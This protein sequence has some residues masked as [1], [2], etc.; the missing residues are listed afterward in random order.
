MTGRAIAEDTTVF[1]IFGVAVV[2]CDCNGV[3]DALVGDVLGATV[4][5]PCGF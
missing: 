1:Q 5:L 4:C 3:H 2:L